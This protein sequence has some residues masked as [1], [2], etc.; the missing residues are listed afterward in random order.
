MKKNYTSHPAEGISS[1]KCEKMGSTTWACELKR[2][3][4]PTRTLYLFDRL[5]FRDAETVFYR[6]PQ[7]SEE[8]ICPTGDNIF[9]DYSG[10]NASCLVKRKNGLR[11]LECGSTY[12]GIR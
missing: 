3:D 1:I 5:E 9:V 7:F 4:K 2:K 8:E 11:I 10:L 12:R 6:E